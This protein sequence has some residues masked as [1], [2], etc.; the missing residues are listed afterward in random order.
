[1]VDVGTSRRGGRSALKEG[2]GWSVAGLAVV[3]EAV[4]VEA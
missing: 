4:R 1:M 3:A 2:G